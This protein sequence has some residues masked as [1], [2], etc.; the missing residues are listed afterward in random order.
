MESSWLA[1]IHATTNNPYILLLL[2]SLPGVCT[3]AWQ[4]YKFLSGNRERKEDLESR[5]EEAARTRLDSIQS[6]MF[7]RLDQHIKN[8]EEDLESERKRCGLLEQSQRT[9][10][11]KCLLWERLAH[12]KRHLA[13]NYIQNI[14]AILRPRGM[15]SLM[16]GWP[17]NPELPTMDG[18]ESYF[19][20]R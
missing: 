20:Q 14:Q 2:A 15:L 3:A 6:A 1:L 4:V 10:Y 17:P 7:D 8:L 9:L 12:D 19:N 13:V 16:E 18:V 5:R 11:N